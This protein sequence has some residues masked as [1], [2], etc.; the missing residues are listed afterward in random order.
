MGQFNTPVALIIFNRPDKTKKLFNIISTIKP[1]KL[2]IIA[3]GPRK[4]V[5]G[6]KAIC[7]QTRQIIKSVNWRCELFTN[8][9]E[10][11][12]GCGK[13]PSTGISWVFDNVDRAIIL[14]D[15]CVPHPSFFPFCEELLERYKDDERIMM[16]SGNNFQFGNRQIKYS[17]YFSIFTHI[18]GW[19]TWKRAW[20]HY[21]Y[22]ISQWPEV[23]DKNFLENYFTDKKHILYW[24]SLF[25]KVYSDPNKTYWDYQW[26]LSCWC[27]NALT[28]IPS[29]NIVSNEGVGDA[30]THTS[31]INKFMN[32]ETFAMQFPLKHPPFVIRNR[33]ADLF[34]Q[35]TNFSVS[36]NSFKKYYELL[37]NKLI[38][39]K[40]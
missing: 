1:R 39:K 6:E 24:R 23:R 35:N 28:I 21:D 36:K 26:L 15:D 4:S 22:K 34:T 17:Y 11:N 13:R 19:A 3:D 10:E 18:W 27:Q 40:K 5:P 32:M 9:S 37:K 8:F 16:I 25:D 31:E 20:E 38:V 14:E 33:A 29:R 2:F 7:E 30:A 12:L